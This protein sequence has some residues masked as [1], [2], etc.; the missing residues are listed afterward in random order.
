MMV[1]MMHHWCGD[2]DVILYSKLE[3]LVGVDM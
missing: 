2:E 1:V 3:R